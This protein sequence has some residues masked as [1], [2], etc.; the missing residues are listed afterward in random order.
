MA[1]LD[2]AGRRLVES[3]LA[4]NGCRTLLRH[5]H[6]GTVAYA[7]AAGLSW[8]EIDQCC[9]VGVCEAA[10]RWDVGRG[11]FLE[12]TAGRYVVAWMRNAVQAEAR[13]RF[14]ERERGLTGDEAVSGCESG[15]D[16]EFVDVVLSQATAEERAVFS[17]HFGLLFGGESLSERGT[18][19]ALGLSVNRVR[20]AVKKVVGRCRH[21]LNYRPRSL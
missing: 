13:G 12:P 18:A 3:Y 1:R 4:R 6:P 20:W 2:E 16:R 8:G 15:C 19:A 7:R 10:A 11:D 9:K 5:W 14:R 17:A 21:G